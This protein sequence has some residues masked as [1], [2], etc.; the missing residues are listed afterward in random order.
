MNRMRIWAMG[1]IVVAAGAVCGQTGPGGPTGET[2]GAGT[3]PAGQ[4]RSTADL[5]AAMPDR[6]TTFLVLADL[7]DVAAKSVLF[8]QKTGLRLPIQDSSVTDMISVKVGVR[9]GVAQRGAMGIAYLDPV[10][11]RGRNA[12]F[13]VPVA[14][15]E[16]FLEYNAADEVEDGLYQMTETRVP[17]FFIHRNGYALFTESLRTCRDI[18]DGTSGIAPRLTD[19]QRQVLGQSDLFVHVD[20]RR[21]L[22]SRREASDRFRR[23][24]A[25]K[26]MGDPTLYA[27]SDML[28]TYLGA[29]DELLE[30]LDSFDLGIRLGAD[31]VAVSALCRFAED[32][33]IYRNLLDMGGSN[34]SL[35]GDLPLDLPHV[36]VSGIQVNPDMLKV[37]LATVTDFI[38]QNSPQAS[39]KVQP[40]TREALMD[41]VSEMADQFTG[42]FE[43]MTSL[44]DPASGAT[45]ANVTIMRIKDRDMFNDAAQDF[46]GTLLKVGDQAGTRVILQYKPAVEEYRGVKISRLEPKIEF[47]KKRFKELF[48]ERARQVYGPDGYVY[49][50]AYLKDRAIVSAGSDQTLFKA[51][52]DMALDEKAGTPPKQM[53]DV[54]HSL[55]DMRNVEMYLS[56]PAMLGRSLVLA[57]PSGGAS[58]KPVVFDEEDRKAISDQGVVGLVLGLDRGRIRLD[59]G[60]GYDQLNKAVAFAE[61]FLPPSMPEET[62]PEPGPTPEPTPTPVPEPA[63]EATPPPAGAP[64]PVPGPTPEPGSGETTP[65]P[66][67]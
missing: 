4:A 15:L 64:A 32:G 27:Y 48:E 31:D 28:L 56:L 52:I 59:T 2:G 55:P 60:L 44:P 25:T 22:E 9:G 16:Q 65:P 7:G 14:G 38:I 66:A 36:S 19:E 29:I 6:T 1:V 8:E 20:M 49:R 47:E 45:E 18:R 12:V 37:A 24:M 3:P 26:V 62:T 30:Q 17:R 54:R 11:Y 23:S 46:F 43:M 51:A 33:S 58:R 13:M 67:T 40:D 61:R 42:Q 63:D 34:S 57:G 39:R 41:A 10:A 50:L 21:T 35:V 53:D 5:L